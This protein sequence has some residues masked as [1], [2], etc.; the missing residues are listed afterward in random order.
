MECEEE[1]QN[2][3]DLRA[4]DTL[5]VRSAD[6]N[7]SG[8]Y[9][10]DGLWEEEISK[11]VTTLAE[12]GYKYYRSIG[13]EN[14]ACYYRSV[15]YG[16]IEMIVTSGKG[17]TFFPFFMNL[18]DECKEF[19]EELKKQYRSIIQC[20][21]NS[22]SLKT[23]FNSRKPTSLSDVQQLFLEEKFDKEIVSFAKLLTVKWIV[24]NKS[25]IFPIEISSK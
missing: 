21:F 24:N 13:G 10:I 9:P 6:S 18:L 8:I 17:D 25:K 5:V 1:F 16:V 11:K 12:G 20:G 3:S 4:G 7:V 14:N 23:T 19:K 15:M 22:N 2:F